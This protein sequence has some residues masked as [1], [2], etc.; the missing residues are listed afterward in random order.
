MH[1]WVNS[2]FVCECKVDPSAVTTGDRI[3]VSEMIGNRIASS[4]IWQDD[5]AGSV[6]AECE[7]VQRRVEQ[8]FK[9]F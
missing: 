9:P 7:R 6:L 1:L 5:K 8:Y 4:R 2:I 3:A